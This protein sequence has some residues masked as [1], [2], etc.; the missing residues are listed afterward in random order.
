MD[1]L[2]DLPLQ[3]KKREQ[4]VTPKVLKWFRENYKGSCA[5][6]I[7]SSSGGKISESSVTSDQRAAL[8]SASMGSIVHKIADSKRKNPF[9]A[10]VLH[11]VPGYVVACFQNKGVALVIRIEKWKGASYET[12]CEFRI[13]L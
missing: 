3:R 12:P 10:F 4:E 6:E 9:D 11:K 2:P 1:T 8:K 13:D 5:I 7:K